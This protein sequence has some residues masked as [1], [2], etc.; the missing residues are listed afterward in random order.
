MVPS[1]SVANPIFDTHKR[2]KNGYCVSPIIWQT[3][4]VLQINSLLV[5]REAESALAKTKL[6]GYAYSDW[7]VRNQIRDLEIKITY[8]QRLLAEFINDK[9]NGD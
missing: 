8:L 4:N 5:L 6:T 2:G 3:G 1:K 9:G 7:C